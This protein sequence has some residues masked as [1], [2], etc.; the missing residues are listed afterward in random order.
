MKFLLKRLA[1]PSSH[2]SL[3]AIFASAPAALTGNPV[4]I[5]SLVAGLI[6]ILVPEQSAS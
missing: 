1:E 3:A 6:G 4:A 5:A 2:A